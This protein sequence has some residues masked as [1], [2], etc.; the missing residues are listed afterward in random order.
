MIC[1]DPFMRGV[2]P[3]GCTKCLPC[4]INRRR[5]WSFRIFLEALMHKGKSSFVTLTY[6]EDS[7]PC[8]GSLRALD[9]QLFLKRLRRMCPEVKIRYFLAAEYGEISQRP[10]FHLALFGLPVDVAGGPS[11][12]SG[13]VQKAWS[14]KCSEFGGVG[15][16]K[17][18]GF[19]HVGT[20]TMD[21]CQYIAGY[22]TKKYSKG[23]Q[24]KRK[25]EFCR[26]SLKPGIGADAMKVVSRSLLQ[27]GVPLLASADVPGVLRSSG[28]LWPLGRY[29]K[30]KL[31]EALGRGSDTPE[32][33]LEEYGKE[34]SE[35][36]RTDESCSETEARFERAAPR[37]WKK[38]WKFVD[39]NRQKV[40]NAHAKFN[41]FKKEK[42]L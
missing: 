29:L 33:V 19:T 4:K 5:L 25:K 18:L 23:D 8:D 20:I 22:I 1:E 17:S 27:T 12:R 30:G 7:V 28:R 3:C 14:V 31:R 21:S 40:L 16:Y 26:M 35:L 6:S 24:W 34:M 15:V 36:L 9:Y 41:L 13:V 37:K 39:M 2:I 38:K 42:K 11:G 10:H 32:S